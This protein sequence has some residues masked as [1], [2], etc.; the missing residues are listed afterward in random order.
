MGTRNKIV[1]SLL[2]E[3]NQTKSAMANALGVSRSAI[4]QWEK[5]GTDPTFEQ[6]VTLAQFFNVPLSYIYAEVKDEW[7]PKLTEEKAA[8]VARIT[9]DSELLITIEEYYSLSE[10]MKQFIRNMVHDL[11]V[12][13]IED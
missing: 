9:K 4:S 7:Q 12:R 1:F 5:N 8:L 11:T 10:A 2:K 6:C 3:Q 13:D